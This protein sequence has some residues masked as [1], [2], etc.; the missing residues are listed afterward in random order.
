V[1][2]VVAQ[3]VLMLTIAVSW[4]FPPRFP[5]GA[6]D[7]VGGA[8]ALAGV[9]LAVWAYRALGAAFTPFPEPRGQRVTWGPYRYLRHPMYG[10]GILFF[11]G[12]SLIFSVA[13]L[14]LT[15]ALALLWWR[16]GRLEERLL[17]ERG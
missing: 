2:W 9:A 5:D 4:L 11:A 17:A 7:L 15:A 1:S 10:G 8:L 3:S 12:M 6:L 13:G 16:K 14:V